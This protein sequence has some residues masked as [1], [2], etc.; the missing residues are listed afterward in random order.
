MNTYL[1]LVLLT[2][3]VVNIVDISGFIST[4]KHWLWK[5]LHPNT[6]YRDFPF[7]P[8]G[9]SYCMTHH[10]GLLYLLISGNFTLPAYVF[11]LLLAYLTPVIG[12]ALQMVYDFLV[13]LINVVYRLLGIQ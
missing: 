1:V 13:S 3:V 8:F 9:C 5:W 7:K 4:V 2:L 10:V 6:L 11:L 12:M